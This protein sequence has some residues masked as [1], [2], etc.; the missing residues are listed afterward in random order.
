MQQRCKVYAI[1]YTF[2]KAVSKLDY[3]DNFL[4]RVINGTTSL[5]K[6]NKDFSRFKGFTLVYH[7]TI[8][9][10]IKED[11]NSRMERAGYNLSIIDSIDIKD[12]PASRLFIMSNA[13]E[14]ICLALLILYWEF[15]PAYYSLPYL[16]HLCS[17]FTDLPKTIFP[18][19]TFNS[20]RI[21]YI[22]CNARH[23]IRFKSRNEY[24]GQEVD[25]CYTSCERFYEEVQK[26]G[27]AYLKDIRKVHYNMPLLSK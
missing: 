15:K 2:P 7:K 12:E 20:Q 17:H 24:S 8:Y 4:L 11:Y 18:N 16:M 25:K 13:I 23:F 9:K 1:Y 21:F 5:F 6:D 19:N 27:S 10:Q 26:L 3:G 22:L 14:Q